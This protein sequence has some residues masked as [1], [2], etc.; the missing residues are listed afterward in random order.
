[1]RRTILGGLFAVSLVLPAAASAT[2]V[3]ETTAREAPAS[4]TQEPAPTPHG[5]ATRTNGPGNEGG[6]S[7]GGGMMGG[8]APG[9]VY[10][11]NR[12]PVD[13]STQGPVND[14]NPRTPPAKPAP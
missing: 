1:M 6:A 12:T 4:Q 8:N 10:E 9:R 13:T 14:V 5:R 3:R 7:L 11:P 2:V